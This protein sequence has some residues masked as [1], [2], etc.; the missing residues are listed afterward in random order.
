MPRATSHTR[1]RRK[2]T[3]PR[4]LILVHHTSAVHLS[5]FYTDHIATDGQKVVREAATFPNQH[6]LHPFSSILEVLVCSHP[7]EAHLSGSDLE[8]SP[9]PDLRQCVV[10]HRR[11]RIRLYP[12]ARQ[13]RGLSDPPRWG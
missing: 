8:Y 4:R 1:R 11:E 13:R 6:Y 12:K 5:Y 2:I 10:A 7:L 9:K 3:L